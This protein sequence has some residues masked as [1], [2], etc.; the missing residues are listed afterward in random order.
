ML[1]L[2]VTYE[3]VANFQKWWLLQFYQLFGMLFL[4][5]EIS[6]T[7]HMLEACICF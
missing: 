3:N 4:R 6:E 2:K 1:I 7:G 5:Q